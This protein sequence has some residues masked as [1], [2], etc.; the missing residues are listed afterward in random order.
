VAAETDLKSLRGYKFQIFS[1][2]QAFQKTKSMTTLFRPSRILISVVLLTAFIHVKSQ[3]SFVWGKQFGSLEEDY[4]L[5]HVADKDG[6][7]YVAGKTKGSM[8]GQNEGLN[9]GYIIKIDSLSNTVWTRQFGTPQNDDVQWS[10]IDEKGCV[11]IAGITAGSMEG[12]NRG[13]EDIFVVKYNPDGRLAWTK[14]FG[15]DS[16]DMAQGIYAD[17]MGGIYIAG[18]TL[19]V[20]GDQSFGGMDGILIKINENG[21]RVYV[22][23]FGTS[24]NDNAVGISGNGKLLFITGTTWGDLGGKNLGLIDAFAGTFSADGKPVRF[25]QL[26]TDGFDIGLQIVA[27]KD[28]NLYVGGTTSGNLEQSQLGQGDC[29][30]TKINPEGIIEWNRQFGTP[31]HD[32]VRGIEYNNKSSDNILVSG[33][34]NLPP[35]KTFLRMYDP[36]G[37]L[38][39]EKIFLGASG[40]DNHLA[41]NGDIY[42]LA[43][44]GENIF[45]KLIG[46]TDVILVKIKL[47]R[48]FMNL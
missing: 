40:K 21:E 22:S 3:T 41:E 10:A 46:V 45:G 18:G 13:K 20:L 12:K 36:R 16:T 30:L 28:N 38:L 24:G 5:N 43:L 25:I 9:D 31:N 8:D 2:F 7:I 23:Q 48:C 11:Y 6:N 34:I 4:T 19:G 26:G 29:F 47:D 42:L 33:V 37:N 44:T 32:G 27:D 15:T 14:Q 17:K 1:Y 35:A 39:W